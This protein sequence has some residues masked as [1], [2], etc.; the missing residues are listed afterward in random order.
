MRN[1]ETEANVVTGFAVVVLFVLIAWAST[2]TARD[3]RQAREQR[4]RR[5]AYTHDRQG[6]DSCRALSASGE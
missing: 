1:R 5:E 3:E 6:P 2:S 4:L